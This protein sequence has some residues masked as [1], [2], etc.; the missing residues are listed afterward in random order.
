VKR[1]SGDLT[2]ESR[3]NPSSWGAKLPRSIDLAAKGW[4][5]LLDAL[6]Q[7]VVLPF[8]LTSASRGAHLGQLIRLTRHRRWIQAAK[9]RTVI[10]VGANTGQFSSA[11][12]ALLPNARI[13]AFEPLPDC[14]SRLTRR[15]VSRADFKAFMVALGD[16]SS[17]SILWR[18]SFSESSSLLTMTDLH[19]EAF[20]WSARREAQFV[21]VR[22]LDS[23]FPQLR[24]KSR[25][26]LKIDVQGFEDRVLRGAQQMLQHIDYVLVEVSFHDLYEEQ[27][28]FD[29][30]YRLLLAQGFYFGGSLDQL[31]SPTDGT[32]LE[33][34]ALFLR[35]S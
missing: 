7:P 9:I 8:L 19:K 25:V 30:V 29:A 28:S 22:T 26:L 18:S 21:T 10:D 31:S 27:A 13:Y 3:P 20:P 15:L 12:A 34:D 1:L 35:R 14:F 32:I 11:M 4:G 6:E 2:D 23:Y 24:L 5:Y 16:Q 33:A 17:E